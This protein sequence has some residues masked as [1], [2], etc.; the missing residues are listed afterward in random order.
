[1]GQQG[2]PASGRAGQRR[3]NFGQGRLS[4]AGQPGSG[5]SSQTSDETKL[6]GPPSAEG[7]RLRFSGHSKVLD[8]SRD[9]SKRRRKSQYS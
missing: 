9:I 7:R 8:W 6:T 2:E 5:N 1:M 4:G 3:V